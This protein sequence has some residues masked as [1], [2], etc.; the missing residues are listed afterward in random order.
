MAWEVVYEICRLMGINYWESG[1]GMVGILRVFSR[2]VYF[3]DLYVLSVYFT[4]LK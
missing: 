2:R 3:F 4:L 1:S